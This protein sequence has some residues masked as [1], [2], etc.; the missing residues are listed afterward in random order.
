[1]NCNE[2]LQI[3]L[4][5]EQKQ[6]YVKMAAARGVLLSEWVKTRLDEAVRTE[7]VVNRVPALTEFD[8]NRLRIPPDQDVTQQ[9][10]DKRSHEPFNINDFI[11]TPEMHAKY[12]AQ[13]DAR[14]PEEVSEEREREMAEIQKQLDYEDELGGCDEE[15]AAVVEED[16]KAEEEA[17]QAYLAEREEEERSFEKEFIP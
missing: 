6:S 2:L 10:W 11:V 9:E 3:R 13:R 4:S 16:R 7:S 1:M 15:T 14:T 5:T 17:E 12:L 8:L